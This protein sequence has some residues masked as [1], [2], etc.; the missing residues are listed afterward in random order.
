MSQSPELN[1]AK[2]PETLST[3]ILVNPNSLAGFGVVERRLIRDY[4]KAAT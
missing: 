1:P 2:Q 4:L 3:T